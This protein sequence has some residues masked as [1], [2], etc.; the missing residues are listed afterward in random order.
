[1]TPPDD[2]AMQALADRFFDAVGRGDLDAGAACYAP[3]V[4]VWH[5]RDEAWTDLAQNLELIGLFFEQ[6]PDWRYEIERRFYTP[7]GFV[8]Q[9]VVHGTGNGRTIRLPVC[10]VAMVE[11]GLIVRMWEYFNAAG[12]P[13]AGVVQDDRR[14]AA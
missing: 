12:S 8:Q 9:H 6:M 13:L 2:T 1:M 11:N 14:A 10:F 4:M 5:S 3:Q 7:D